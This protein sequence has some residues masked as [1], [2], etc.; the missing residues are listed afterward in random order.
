MPVDLS[1][2]YREWPRRA[3]LD[4]YSWG[5]LFGIALVVLVRR[6]AVASTVEWTLL[7]CFLLAL[8]PTSGI[9]PVAQ[10]RADRF[11]YLPLAFA[12]L[13][14]ASLV[15]RAAV[16]H[17]SVWAAGAA[18]LVLCGL[19]SGR[20]LEAWRSDVTLWKHVLRHDPS[21][22]M[23]NGALAAQALGQGEL[24][25]AKRLL[26]RALRE[27]PDSPV[28]WANLGRY[29]LYRAGPGPLSP[30][31]VRRARYLRRAAAA[32]RRAA[33]LAPR[34]ASPRAVLARIHLWRG[35][36]SAALRSARAALA[37]PRCP[38]D[39]ALL[40]GDLLWSAGRRSAARS[41]VHRYCD[42]RPGIA[43]CSR[44]LAGHR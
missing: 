15:G 5:G 42:R 41:A 7:G 30:G 37:L 12:S 44:W 31:Q 39:A 17:R 25:L 20:Y 13:L 32:L 34:F 19:S 16:R 35:E 8:L 11:L 9:V 1:P 4:P 26:D 28:S 3:W 22:P 21:H 6:R 33:K 40:A 18:A 23:A 29:W 24:E 36:R 14:V 43:S 2:S 27:S 38:P 10:L